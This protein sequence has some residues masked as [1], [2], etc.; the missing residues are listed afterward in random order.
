M[1]VTSI[2]A[3]YNPF[4]NGHKYHLEQSKKITNS[5]Y[6]IVVMSGNYVQRG[7]PAILDK[8]V[9]TKIALQS[10]A[11]IVI[12]LPSIYST[13]SAEFF[14]HNAVSILDK[15]NIV[16]SICFG[17]EIGDIEIIKE[18]A[19]ILS[20]EPL[21][22]KA[23]LKEELSKGISFPLA[24]ANALKAYIHNSDFIESPNNILAIEYIKSIIKLK[25]NIK[26][27][28]IKRNSDY[29]SAI[30]SDISSATAIRQAIKE[31]KDFINS[32]PK[33]S[34]NILFEA[35]SCG[36]APIFFDDFS[37]LL[38]YKLRVNKNLSDILDINEGLEN[39][40]INS[41]KY[42]FNISDITK[43][44][45]TK[46]YTYTRIQRALLHIILGL[47][48]SDLQI[49]NNNIQYI[50][51]LGFRKQSEQVL[52]AL[53][54][55][56]SIY[57]ITNTK[58]SINELNTLGLNMLNQEIKFTDIYFLSNPNLKQRQPNKEFTMPIVIT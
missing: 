52:S 41:S 47:K 29:H 55:N 24:R 21:E 2:I 28:T 17:S 37:T 9:R 6:C 46:R 16:E 39:R 20:T 51:I 8:W 54:K 19:N 40:I 5:D 23:M 18:F 48:K 4:H 42:N 57:V 33:E 53:C 14:A 58:K 49:Y 32:I 1:K 31:K 27:Y 56:S 7:E 36:I 38:N 10:G 43:S 26:P 25:S 3:E 15:T 50:K 34:A 35:I 11:D 12:E 30:L 45:K 22:Y 44:I 13:S